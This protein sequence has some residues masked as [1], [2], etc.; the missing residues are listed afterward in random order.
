[1]FHKKSL[2]INL[3][4]INLCI[5][6]LLGATLR[7]KILFPLPFLNYRN[8]LSA[9]S[10]FAFSGWVGMILITLLIFD[11]LPEQ[12]HQKKVYK[13]IL[14]GFEFSSLGM[15]FT[16]PFMGYTVI[17]TFFSSL[18]IFIYFWF[19]F[20]FIKDLL[21][22]DT[23][24]NVKLLGVAAIASLIISSLGPLG[25]VYILL[26]HSQNSILYRDSVYTFLHFQYNGFFSLSVF[27]LFFNYIF[28]KGININKAWPFSLSITLYVVPSLFL[29]LLWHNNVLFYIFSA[30]GCLLII[31]TLIFFLRSTNV[32]PFSKLFP[33][34]LARS[35]WWLCCF[36]FILK[37]ILQIG[38]MFPSLGDAVYGD[39]P[40][41]IGFL[42]LVFLGFVTFYILAWLI[43]TGYFTKRDKVVVYPFYVFAFAVIMNELVLMLQGLSV[44][45]RTN[46]FLFNWYLWVASLLLFLGALV[47]VIARFDVVLWQKKSHNEYG[48]KKY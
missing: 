43:E 14:I 42:H 2:W 5:V 8:V 26:S 32:L 22:I 1:M 19:A 40:V 44:L 39:R 3:C 29:A 12:L 30:I 6:A 23:D 4:L 25:L 13:W 48:F 28:K 15:A 9:H 37:M 45:F 21:R 36:S 17:S 10:H 24:K 18:Y 20:V 47:I 33:H 11:L 27:T 35:L 7:S 41:I 46:S 16:F 31:S 38:T 34:P